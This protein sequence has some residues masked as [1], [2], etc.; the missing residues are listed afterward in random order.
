MSSGQFSVYHIMTF[1]FHE[2]VRSNLQTP[3]STWSVPLKCMGVP[4][5]VVIWTGLRI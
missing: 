3:T 5:G 2:F 1:Y 4:S